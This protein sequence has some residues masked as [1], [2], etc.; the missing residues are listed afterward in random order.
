PQTPAKRK[1]S[2]PETG[3]ASSVILVS[4]A[5]TSVASLGTSLVLRRRKRN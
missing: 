5:L 1:S 4:T 3:D 2:L